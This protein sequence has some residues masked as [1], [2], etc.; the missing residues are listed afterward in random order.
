MTSQLDGYLPLLRERA[1]ALEIEL[2]KEKEVVAEIEKCDQGEL[3]DW[4]AT[5][6]DTK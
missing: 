2:G 3:S 6:L 4:R 5:V 1:A